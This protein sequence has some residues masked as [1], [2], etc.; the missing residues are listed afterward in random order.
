MVNTSATHTA[1]CYR[2]ACNAQRSG[3]LRR[4]EPSKKALVICPY[5]FQVDAVTHGYKL[6]QPDI[7]DIRR[8]VFSFLH[9][10]IAILEYLI[11]ISL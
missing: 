9:R 8:R 2:L 7:L 1:E 3:I 10:V 6:S 11:L 4:V 5:L